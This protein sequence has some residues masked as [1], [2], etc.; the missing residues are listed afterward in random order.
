LFIVIG[1]IVSTFIVVVVSTFGTI[2]F[3]EGVNEDYEPHDS[4]ERV[5]DKVGEG[6]GNTDEEEERADSEFSKINK[7][8]EEFFHS[9][10]FVHQ[11][12]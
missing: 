5:K 4:E 8:I 1:V 12:K 6:A 3:G 7:F 11:Y 10:I 9:K 2:E